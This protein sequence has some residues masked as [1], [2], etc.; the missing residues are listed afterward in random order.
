MFEQEIAKKKAEIENTEYVSKSMK[1]LFGCDIPG[2]SEMPVRKHRHPL[3]PIVGEYDFDPKKLRRILINLSLKNPIMLLGP[4][5]SGKTS[6][7]EQFYARL[8]APYVCFNGSPSVD[9]DLLL[10]RLDYD[11]ERVK[12]VDGIVTACLREGI[13][14]CLDEIAAV[15][16]RVIVGLHA[17][18]EKS[19]TITLNTS[20]IDPEIGYV[21]S[22]RKASVVRHP[23]FQFWA[24]DNTGGKVD[25]AV[26]YDRNVLDCATRS[27]F[28]TF[29]WNY[30]S[31]EKE[32][33][34]LKKLAPSLDKEHVSLLVDYANEI[35]GLFMKEE[36]FE[37][38]S[39]REL[40]RWAQLAQA[41]GNL[42]ESFVDGVFMAF[43]E[44][45]QVAMTEIW[46][47]KMGGELVLP[48]AVDSET[49]KAA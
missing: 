31:P 12:Q 46:G 32:K 3:S 6:F 40:I 20:G 41:Y 28:S 1:S 10:G 9:E 5:G 45:D 23:L 34:L 38:L 37:P 26:G 42:D 14:F 11:G 17:I 44:S 24:T 2:F 7:V 30:M 22:I 48:D 47:E 16:N 35:R 25:G 4:K 21:E 39:L 15:P 27:R 29:D 49:A 18:L 36:M 43:N 8:G 33:A 13:P 19:P